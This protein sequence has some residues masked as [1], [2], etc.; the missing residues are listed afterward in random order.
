M[1]TRTEQLRG[2]IGLLLLVCS[3]AISACATL[4]EGGAPPNG[5]EAITMDEL[6][7]ESARDAYTAIEVLRPLMLHG[8]GA[9]SYLPGVPQEPE[10][11]VDGVYF[12]PLGSL[13]LLAARDLAAIR[14]LDIAAAG[15]EYGQG[16]PAGV[17]DIRTRR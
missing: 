2:A 5:R 15:V 17:I 13:H 12:G 8:R 9:T 3:V 1:M 16:H 11:F 10:V 4:S 14:W 7:Q 6:I